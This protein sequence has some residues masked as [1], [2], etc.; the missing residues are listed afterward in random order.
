MQELIA[1]PEGYYASIPVHPEE[2]RASV[3]FR[4]DNSVSLNAMVRI[5]PAGLVTTGV[6]VATILLSVTA[7]VWVIRRPG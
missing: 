4:V 3:E 2:I 7:L 6:M 1:Q 5:T